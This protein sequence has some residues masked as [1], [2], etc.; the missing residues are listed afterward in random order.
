MT[1]LLK[2]RALTEAR[3]ALADLSAR[4]LRLRPSE[5]SDVSLSDGLAGVALVHAALH[6]AF[7]RAGHGDRAERLLERAVDRLGRDE[8]S[9]GLHLGLAGL[10]WT[11]LHLLDPAEHGTYADLFAPIDAAL[12]EWVAMSPSRDRFDV[13][14]GLAGIG[15]YALERLPDPSAK[16]LLAAIVARLAATARPQAVGVAWRSDPGWIACDASV[17]RPENQDWGLGLAHGAAGVIALLGRVVAAGVETSAA[18]ALLGDAVAWL[19]SHELPRND[20]SCFSYYAVPPDVRRPPARAAWCNG[21]PGIAAALLVAA[22]A[23]GTR[24]WRS[25]AVRIGL[26]AAA[27]SPAGAGVLDAG[28]CHGA[29]G[30][31][32]IFHRLF[33]STRDERFARASRRWFA[34][35]LAMRTRG[36]GFAGF[37]ALDPDRHHRLAWRSAPGFLT[38][39]AGIALALVAATTGVEPAW[40]RALLLS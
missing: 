3:S 38:G 2:G 33:L 7:P 4:Y 15:V 17:P 26:R 24:A 18:R 25:A 8:V 30:V 35:T 13:V 1:V 14:Y 29:S 5:L 6:Q 40:D 9:P 11:A 23:T 22:N 10:G 34:R 27:R 12:E 21:D 16:R 32:H 20:E 28:L 31:A 37:R 36:R 39:G 19:L